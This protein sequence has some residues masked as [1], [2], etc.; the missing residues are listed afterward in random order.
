MRYHCTILVE[1]SIYGLRA[2]MRNYTVDVE[3]CPAEKYLKIH[4]ELSSIS[5]A[6][7]GGSHFTSR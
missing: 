5:P 6:S 1:I 2:R 7:P 4:F 3:V